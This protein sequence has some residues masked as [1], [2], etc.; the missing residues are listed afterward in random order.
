MLTGPRSGSR[1]RSPDAVDRHVAMRFRQRR[2][3]LG[4][5][6]ETAARHLRLSRDRLQQIEHE[7]LPLS[8]VRLARA[9][10]LLDVSPSY[11]FL[12]FKPAVGA[13]EE[14][15]MFGRSLA[16]AAC[17]ATGL[18]TARA[19]AVEITLSH[20]SGFSSLPLMVM[21][22]RHLVEKHASALGL[23]NVTVTYAR[24]NTGVLVNEALVAGRLQFAVAGVAP[25]LTAWD[26]TRDGLGIK[27]LSSLGTT[28][29]YLV[30]RNP[31]IHSVAD[32]TD[33]D[34]INVV[35]PKSALQAVLL[36]MAA[37]RAF[38]MAEHTKLDRLTIGVPS[39]VSA[40]AIVS[41]NGQITA[42][43]NSPP[44]SYDELATPGAHVVVSSEELL[45]G[46]GTNLLLYTSSAVYEENPKAVAAVLAAL[47]EAMTLIQANRREAS[48]AYLHIAG[49]E[50]TADL[51]RM[52]DDPAIVFDRAPHRIGRYA[53]F[54]H[55]IG[56]LA[57]K[58]Q[59]WRELFF[60]AVAQQLHGD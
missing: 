19:E 2:A 20:L 51:L 22:D 30:T 15:A 56:M 48:E 50:I 58:P 13:T 39:S 46:P 43:F 10:A 29:S 49:T 5:P 57:A 18:T 47:D 40:G 4:I 12:G 42:D 14:S 54:M 8:S 21:E 33:T 24:L 25:F 7:G 60:P 37:A 36:E 44:W 55:D 9:C 26:R 27:A 41:G 28:P 45:G 23:T 59:D 1:W 32:F 34:R 52:V 53:E 38:G 31:G 6:L 3:D 35:A 17:L 16:V 11:F